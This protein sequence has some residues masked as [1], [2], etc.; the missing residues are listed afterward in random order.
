[1]KDYKFS[2]GQLIV[3]RNIPIEPWS[4]V[5]L[6]GIY[7][8]IG[9]NKALYDEYSLIDPEGKNVFFNQLYMETRYKALNEIW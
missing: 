8:V 2:P 1:M 9:I 3:R 4:K 6:P 5:V 7:V